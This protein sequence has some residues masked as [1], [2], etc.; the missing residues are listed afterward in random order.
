[1]ERVVERT[2]MLAAYRRVWQNKGSPGVDGMSVEDLKQCL[3]R[4]WDGIREQL[5]AGT[6]QP[7]PVKRQEI[8]KPGGGTRQLGIPTVLDRLIQQ[9]LLQVLQPI[10]E[11]GFSDHST[12]TGR[13]AVRT[14]RCA[15]RN[16]S[17]GPAL[18]SGRGPEIG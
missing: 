10:F 4:D 13:G 17:V 14:M 5:L 18:G 6:Y 9:C 2:N 15:A 12:A 8:P 11:P 1:M 7:Q 16:T 3:W